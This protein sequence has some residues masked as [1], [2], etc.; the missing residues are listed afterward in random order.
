MLKSSAKHLPLMAF[1]PMIFEKHDDVSKDIK[2]ARDYDSRL[3][4]E[5]T[6]KERLKKMF[7]I[8]S[9]DGVSPELTSMN[10]AGL[11]GM[12]VGA[13]YGGF[14]HSRK[15][16]VD[17]MERN[18]ATSFAS[19]LDAKKKLQHA[20]TMS[21]GK[22]AFRW[23]WRLG[24]FTYTYVGLVTTISTYRGKSS[25]LEYALAGAGAG[26]FYKMNRGLR[27]MAAGGIFGCAFGTVGGILSL[28][29]L[30]ATGMSME[31]VRY[32][33][34]KWKVDR[35]NTIKARLPSTPNAEED[36]ILKAHDAGLG[37][38]KI[39]LDVLDTTE[40]TAASQKTTK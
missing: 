18:L 14:L 8:N 26:A 27:G 35:Q 7:T 12:F 10:Q 16:Y 15:A 22:G 40:A 1:L 11:I 29:I 4:S 20:V 13:C 9:E 38:K 3:V 32:W 19:H 28:T 2:T 5:E 33:Q 24:L 17:F 21:F 31:E 30:R 6:G 34:Y 39:S 36:P 37:E 25:I 23:G